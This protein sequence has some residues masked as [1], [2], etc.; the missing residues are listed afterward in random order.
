MTEPEGMDRWFLNP[1]PLLD[2]RAPVEFE[3]GSLPGAVNL[4]ILNDEERRLVGTCY[5]NEGSDAAVRLGHELVSGLIKE[6][7]IRSWVEFLKQ[8]PGARIFCWRGG[9]RSSIATQWIREAGQ[10]AEKIE[11]GYKAL[12]RHLLSRLDEIAST[13]K[14]ILITGKTG[15]GKTEFLRTGTHPP[16]I[17]LEAL[18]RHRGSSFGR[19]GPQPPQAG[20]ENLLAAELIRNRGNEAILLEDESVMIGALT[21]PRTLVSAMKAAPVAILECPLG[22][23]IERITR[24]Y[25]ADRLK[26][27]DAPLVL[28]DLEAS[29]LRISKKLGGALTHSIQNK[30]RIGFQS[31]D[32]TSPHS[33]APWISDLLEH[34]YDPFYERAMARSAS[35]VRI[36]GTRNELAEKLG[37]S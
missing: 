9:M 34:Y 25:V 26:E 8:N 6:E 35:R 15:S 1:T 32:L 27:S 3:S 5:R 19:S 33:H 11:G 22:E 20:F 13:Q 4:P 31:S 30:M 18:A 36:R 29:L 10:P 23:R 16:R 7:R 24:E 17:D 12:R 2:V 28:L 37:L 21:L 14:F